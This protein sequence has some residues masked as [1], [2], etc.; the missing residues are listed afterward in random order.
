M[1]N[2]LQ[3]GFN[4]IADRYDAGRRAL[5]PCFDD[6]YGA[7][8]DLAIINNKKPSVIDLGAGTGLLTAML[9]NKFPDAEFT[10]VDLSVNMLNIAR[11]R[12]AG[13][14]GFKFIVADYALLNFPGTYDLVVSSLS[15][16]H[17]DDAD[18]WILYRKIYERLNPGGIFI[19][20]DLLKS[21][22]A[23]NDLMYLQ[24][25]LNK[26]D[27]SGLNDEEIQAARYRM[28]FDKPATVSDNLQNMHKAGFVHADLVYKYY[29]FGVISGLKPEI[30]TLP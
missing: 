25:W 15:I 28:T 14:P 20:G 24:K 4:Q 27:A 6:F 19:N 16:H 17:L 29:N 1:E 23:E 18:K 8:V 22:S 13:L 12:F 3:Q 9:F 30:S 11:Q 2:K 10:L 7:I 21:E 26:I 5:I